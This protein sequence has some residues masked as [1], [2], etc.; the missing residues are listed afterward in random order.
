MHNLF[1]YFDKFLISAG[2]HMD[3]PLC[4][5]LRHLAVLMMTA[6]CPQHFKLKNLIFPSSL[7]ER[8][9]QFYIDRL[10][11]VIRVHL[12]LY[13]GLTNVLWLP[14]PSYEVLNHSQL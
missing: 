9:C 7:H 12:N 5:V 11:V 4:K 10:Y 1:C 3:N 14:L 8:F 13:L 2:S 6:G